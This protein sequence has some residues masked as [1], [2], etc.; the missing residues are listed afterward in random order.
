MILVDQL[1]VMLPLMSAF[2]GE[3]AVA[4]VIKNSQGQT[5]LV[6]VYI[7][8]LNGQKFCRTSSWAIRTSI[9][10]QQTNGGF[11]T[12]KKISGMK[13]GKFIKPQFKFFAN[14]SI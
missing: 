5:T 8:K 10:V 4:C 12:Q 2:T 11:T 14:F 1:T 9:K 3:N 7:I 13:F 6:T